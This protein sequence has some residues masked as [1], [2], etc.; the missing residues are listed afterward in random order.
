MVKPN[1]FLVGAA[2]AGTTSIAQALGQHPN[3][4]ITD[5]K[6]PNFISSLD[7]CD[8]LS[9]T[10][11]A[12]YLKYYRSVTDESII[13]EASVNN[14]PAK[15]AAKHIRQINPDSK[16]LISLRNPLTR[17]QSL[18]EM[19]SRHGLKQSFQFATKT[20]PWLIKQCCY[21]DPVNR[22]LDNF[23]R[24]QIHWIDFDSLKSGWETTMAGIYDFL[25]VEQIDGERPVVRNVGGVPKNK[26]FGLLRNRALI[27]L[28]KKTIPKPLHNFVDKKVKGV[29]FKKMESTELDVSYLKEQ[30]A[31]DV[32]RLDDLLQ[33]NF[34]E[35]WIEAA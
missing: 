17:V 22:Y 30:F 16:I 8:S 4:F 2:K 12:E 9:E 1:F 33:T 10:D 6:E 21:H 19:Y 13:G 3:I 26:A 15:M 34:F 20:D 31:D 18:Y 32:L 29:G 23:P 7:N 25:E 27:N 28:A 11:I 35:K 24:E 14:L 5:P